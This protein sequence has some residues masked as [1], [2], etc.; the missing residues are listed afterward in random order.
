MPTHLH[1]LNSVLFLNSTLNIKVKLIERYEPFSTY[2][3]VW[4]Y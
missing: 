2:V 3:N 1:T 4:S